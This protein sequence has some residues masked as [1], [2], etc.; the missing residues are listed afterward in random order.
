LTIVDGIDYKQW[1]VLV[2]LLFAAIMNCKGQ[3]S[4]TWRVYGW[5]FAVCMAWLSQHCAAPTYHRPVTQYV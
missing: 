4:L 3:G 5:H 1:H 2:V